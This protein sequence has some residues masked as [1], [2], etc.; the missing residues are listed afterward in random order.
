MKTCVLIP[1]YNE[2]L[3]I[4]HI[5]KEI[6][7]M[8]LDVFVVDD[9]ST[10]S[11]EKIAS[12]N[13]AFAI[14]HP[15]NMGKGASLKD[16]FEFILRS[17]NYDAVIIMDADG[18][19]SPTD[20]HKFLSHA[21]EYDDDIIIGNRMGFAKDMPAVRYLTNRFMS[22]VLSTIC[23]QRIPDTQ[24]GYRLIRRRLIEKIKL[25]LNKYDLES[26]ML[27]KASKMKCRVAS[28]PVES[29]YRDEASNIH[30]I[31]DTLRFLNLL[32]RSYFE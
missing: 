17:T 18:Q 10:D 24:C 23:K 21:E 27:I 2:A 9:G 5:V 29:I 4:G 16:G 30:P 28:V 12:E 3:T 22:Y 7:A 31:K 32:L 11:T 20:I 14:R 6:R 13:G 26:E 19:H 8:G 25:E 1:S 15:V